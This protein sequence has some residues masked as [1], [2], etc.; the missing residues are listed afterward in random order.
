M[1]IRPPR[2]RGATRGDPQRLPH[3]HTRASDRS[4]TTTVR[5]CGATAR[6]AWA[7]FGVNHRQGLRLRRMGSPRD[8]LLTADRISPRPARHQ[9]CR[10]TTAV[11]PVVTRNWEPPTDLTGTD[12]AP[13][14][15]Q[16]PH[17]RRPR[18]ATPGSG[19]AR[20]LRLKNFVSEEAVAYCDKTLTRH[21]SRKECTGENIGALSGT[22]TTCPVLF[23]LQPSALPSCRAQTCASG[24]HQHA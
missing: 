20:S 5:G 17:S 18:P 9:L 2:P 19:S 8:R 6:R 24:W 10:R 14:L 13:V 21:T 16:K 1:S 11:P 12:P 23:P 15:S 22:P 4:A 7:P 3:R